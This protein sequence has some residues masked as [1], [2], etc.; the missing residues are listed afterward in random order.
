VIIHSGILAFRRVLE[1]DKSE[2][3]E[4]GMAALEVAIIRPAGS[5]EPRCSTVDIIGRLSAWITV[6]LL[7]GGLIKVLKKLKVS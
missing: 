7:S 2:V 5:L 3:L 1:E 6:V 4:V